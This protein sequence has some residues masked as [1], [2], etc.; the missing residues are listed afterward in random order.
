MKKDMVNR[1]SKL[2]QD[3]REQSSKEQSAILEQMTKN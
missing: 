1:M 3:V 2:K